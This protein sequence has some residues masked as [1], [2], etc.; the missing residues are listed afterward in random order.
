VTGVPKGSGHRMGIDRDRDGYLDGD[1]RDARSDPGNFDSNPTN[2]GVGPSH[3]PYVFAI[4]GVRPNPFRDATEL[5]FTLGGRS[6]V[7]V[8]VFDIMGRQVRG[9]ARG[10]WL[11]AGPQSL[12]WDG[13]DASGVPA[14]AGV[15]FIRL[16]TGHGQWTRMAVRI[17]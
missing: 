17:R 5:A 16:E 8:T 6:R 11:D 2:V 4:R 3:N 13:R 7:T 1:E 14:K 12:R 9:V 10:L 15:Y